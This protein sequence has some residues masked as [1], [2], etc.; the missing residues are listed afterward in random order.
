MADVASANTPL[1]VV[2]SER[3]HVDGE[4]FQMPA[5]LFC[6]LAGEAR[7]PARPAHDLRVSGSMSPQSSPFANWIWWIATG[8]RGDPPESVLAVS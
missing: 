7:S 6:Q 5:Q 3:V 2:V 4:P 8:F 1:L